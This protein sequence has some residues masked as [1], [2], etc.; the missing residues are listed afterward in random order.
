MTHRLN[1]ISFTTYD[2]DSSNSTVVL[3]D[4]TA[5]QIFTALQGNHYTKPALDWISNM[6]Q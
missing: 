5:R 1:L 3:L 6:P 4:Y 2:I